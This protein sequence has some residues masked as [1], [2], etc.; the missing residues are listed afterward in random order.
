[1]PFTYVIGE[2][3]FL[4]SLETIQMSFSLEHM[5]DDEE[6]TKAIPPWVEL[7]YAVRYNFHPS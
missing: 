3:S 5:E 7:E 4:S 2:L 6:T 1:M